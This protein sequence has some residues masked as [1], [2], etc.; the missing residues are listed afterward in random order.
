MLTTL[1]CFNG[2]HH[3]SLSVAATPEDVSDLSLHIART[4]QV[5]IAVPDTVPLPTVDPDAVAHPASPSNNAAILGFKHICLW[6][7]RTA[8]HAVSP[9]S[10]DVVCITSYLNEDGHTEPAFDAYVANTFGAACT[11]MGGEATLVNL[12]SLVAGIETTEE[13][14]RIDNVEQDSKPLV[15][16]QIDVA[17]QPTNDEPIPVGGEAEANHVAADH[18]GEE[19][20]PSDAGG[21]QTCFIFRDTTAFIIEGMLPP[22]LL[23]SLATQR[24]LVPATLGSAAAGTLSV[25]LVGS[26]A[27]GH[28]VVNDQYRVVMES[29]MSRGNT[30]TYQLQ[31]HVRS[32]RYPSR[33]RVRY[34]ARER[35]RYHMKR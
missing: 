3:V 8:L 4:M 30:L 5:L 10:D 11:A 16:E 29:S 27:R 12:A 13:C 17:T 9:A 31:S 20:N 19:E 32:A 6:H 26:T 14:C 1:P 18:G 21:F 7:T 22:P 34:Y 15:A 24:V 2:L 35:Q 25:K 23:L 28:V 33:G